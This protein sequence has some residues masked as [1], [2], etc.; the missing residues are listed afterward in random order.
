MALNQRSDGAL[1]RNFCKVG[2]AVEARPGERDEKLP[3]FDCAAVGADRAKRC[4]G[5]DQLG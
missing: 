2:M 1:G 5:I 3:S 4:I